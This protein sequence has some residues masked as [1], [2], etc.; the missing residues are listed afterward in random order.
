LASQAQEAD[1][2]K[3]DKQVAIDIGESYQPNETTPLLGNESEVSV[4]QN[5]QTEQIPQIL[6]TA[7]GTPGSSQGGN[8]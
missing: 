8:H 5:Q 7:Y 3:K 4:E 6:Q 1:N 2:K